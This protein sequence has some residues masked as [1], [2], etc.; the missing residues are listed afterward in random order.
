MEERKVLSV[1]VSNV[2][3]EIQSLLPEVA[4]IRQKEEVRDTTMLLAMADAPGSW[5]CSHTDRSPKMRWL[6]W[7]FL[8]FREDFSDGEPRAMHNQKCPVETGC[9][10][11][12]RE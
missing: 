4:A 10:V 11:Q 9:A 2:M 8:T 12:A 3:T 7:W 6:N 5:R 1:E